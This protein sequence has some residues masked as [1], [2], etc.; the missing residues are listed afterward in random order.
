M[1]R[2]SSDS[3]SDAALM[4]RAAQGDVE[5]FAQ[6]YDRHAATVLSL[7][8]HVS[9][10]TS[11]EGGRSNEDVLQEVFLEA[12][13][14]A[15]DYNPTRASVRAWLLVRARS[16][17]LDGL[18][19]RGREASARRE[20]A[21]GALRV[22]AQSMP[23]TERRI[24]ISEALATL[25]PEVRMTLELTFFEGMTAAEIA[26]QMQIP[27][28]TVKSRLSRGLSLMERVLFQLTEESR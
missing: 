23:Q 25:S 20:L 13:L 6:I 12:W 8:S 17:A 27:E 10:R 26:V 28:G 3:G 1:L 24:A 4:Q 18:R 22:L 14:N 2:P 19:R 9:Q 21:H 15:Q 7:L 5:A 16:R 11:A